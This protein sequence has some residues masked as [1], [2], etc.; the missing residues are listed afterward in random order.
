[1]LKADHMYSPHSWENFRQQ[2]QTVLRQNWKKFSQNFIA[3][4]ESTQNVF[5]FEKNNQL[6]SLKISQAIDPKKCGYFNARKLF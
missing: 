6:H 3:F 5:D 4:L 2:V 1:M